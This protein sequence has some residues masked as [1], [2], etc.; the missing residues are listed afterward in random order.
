MFSYKSKIEYKSGIME[1]SLFLYP[2]FTK[3]ASWV[4]A[5][6]KQDGLLSHEQLHFDICELYIRK[7]RKTISELQLSLMD[8]A[9]QIRI[10]FDQAWNDY[11]QAQGLYDEESRHGLIEK[12]QKRWEELVQ[13]ELAS[14]QDFATQ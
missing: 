14:L 3:K 5:K 8:P 7:L 12:E 4:I 11:Q 2:C 13:K 1:L 10:Q 6:N 9:G